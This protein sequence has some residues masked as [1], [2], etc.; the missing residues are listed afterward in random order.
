MKEALEEKAM[1]IEE[2]LDNQE[3][4]ETRIAVLEAENKLHTRILGLGLERVERA[5]SKCKH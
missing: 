4:L 3:K 2:K 5:E 1:L